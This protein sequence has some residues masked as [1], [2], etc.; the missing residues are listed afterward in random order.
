MET[1][2]LTFANNPDEPLDTLTEEYLSISRI[3]APAAFRQQYLMHPLNNATLD[4]IAYYL[5]LY[6]ERLSLFL[7]S[8][9]AGR[10]I[11]LMEDGVSRAEGIAHLLGQCPNLKV[12]ILNGCSTE[13]QIKQLHAGGVPVVIATSAPV[14][15]KLATEFSKKLFHGLETGYTIQEAFEQGIGV[16]KAKRDIIVYREIGR[17]IRGRE[18]KQLWGISIHPNFPDA[19]NWKLPSEATESISSR[20][21]TAIKK[22]SIAKR[23]KTRFLKMQLEELEKDYLNLEEDIKVI[24]IDKRLSK[25]RLSELQHQREID[26][27]LYE[28]NRIDTSV[29]DIEKQLE[30]LDS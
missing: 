28:I 11:L 30:L 5:T 17:G 15:D 26:D 24:N 20:I 8:G 2:L 25:D 21:N 10:D 4:E 16:V 6:R 12:V 22:S 3:L 1:L 29:L 9:H 18:Q 7:F 13:G 23:L 27:R 19:G 14:G